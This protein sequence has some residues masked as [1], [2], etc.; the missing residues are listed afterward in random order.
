MTK[1]NNWKRL[2]RRLQCPSPLVCQ[3]GSLNMLRST[4]IASPRR[5]TAMVETLEPRSL[6]SVAILDLQSFSEAPA[7]LE[8]PLIN[9]ATSTQTRTTLAVSGDFADGAT[10]TF[11]ATVSNTDPTASVPTGEVAFL[12][13]RYPTQH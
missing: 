2:V 3:E 4:R 8:V 13:I 5:A 9:Q 7:A 1:L 12:A 11:T 10:L 6:L